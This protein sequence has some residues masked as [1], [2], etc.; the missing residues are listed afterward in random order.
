MVLVPSFQTLKQLTDFHGIWYE[1]QRQATPTGT[2]SFLLL[3]KKHGGS[4]T[5]DIYTI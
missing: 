5:C 4:R 3:S 2:L 1:L